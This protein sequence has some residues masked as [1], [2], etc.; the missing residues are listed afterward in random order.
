MLQGREADYG[1]RG[2]EITAF[3]TRY[4]PRRPRTEFPGPTGTPMAV[5]SRYSLGISS[6]IDSPIALPIRVNQIALPR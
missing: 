3:D 1:S 6:I 5:D 4:S 2:P